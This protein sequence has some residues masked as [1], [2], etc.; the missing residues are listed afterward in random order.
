MV[1]IPG[2]RYLPRIEENLGALEVTLSPA[3]VARISAAVPAGAASGTR[4]PPGAMK[5]VYA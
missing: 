2:T 5:S 1:A 3:D 4:Y